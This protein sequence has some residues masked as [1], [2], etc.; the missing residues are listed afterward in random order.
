MRKL[1]VLDDNPDFAEIVCC[2]GTTAGYSTQLAT[3]AKAFMRIFKSSTP[4]VI[5]LDI[6]MPDVDGLEMLQWLARQGS[7][8]PVI[9]M[10]GHGKPFLNIAAK[11]AEASG[12]R[13]IGSLQK[14]F[15]DSEL[16]ALLHHA[17]ATERARA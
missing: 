14:P 16:R 10:T 2:I 12:V 6:V 9:L 1:M 17:D 11:F 15:A 13:V 7:A 4:S 8:A 3:D 5:V